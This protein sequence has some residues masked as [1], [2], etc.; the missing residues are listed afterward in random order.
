MYHDQIVDSCV[1][2]DRTAIPS[3][4][5]RV[6]AGWKELVSPHKETAIFWHKLWVSN[7]RPRIGWIADV[8]HKIRRNY[9]R[10][11]RWVLRN[12]VSLRTD[13][14]AAAINSNRSRDFGK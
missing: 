9:K 3:P 14:M 5:R 7:G 8:R 4:A 1:S 13:K 11:S 10:L 2:A 6:V 12:Q